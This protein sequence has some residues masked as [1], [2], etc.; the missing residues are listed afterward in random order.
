MLYL[1][2]D[3]ELDETKNVTEEEYINKR[4]VR[5][6]M[7]DG[8]VKSFLILFEETLKSKELLNHLKVNNL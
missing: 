2:Q 3:K 5:T 7:F 4:F 8:L 1:Q 6:W